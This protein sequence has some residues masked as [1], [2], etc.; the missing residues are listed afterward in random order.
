LE[1]VDD[2]LND[3]PNALGIA[4]NLVSSLPQIPPCSFAHFQPSNFQVQMK[5][6]RE[7]RHPQLAIPLKQESTHM[8]F[9]EQPVTI[10]L[11]ATATVIVEWSPPPREI[12]PLVPYPS[13]KDVSST[14]HLNEKQHAMFILAGRALLKSYLYKTPVELGDEPFFAWLS[15]DARFERAV[16]SIPF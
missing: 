12:V 9:H 14:S 8:E 7:S 4:Q 3:I 10:E 13:L 5:E 16:S 1:S 11:F 15:G 6:L 2:D